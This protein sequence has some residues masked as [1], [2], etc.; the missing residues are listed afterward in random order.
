MPGMEFLIKLSWKPREDKDQPDTNV[1]RMPVV[2]HTRVI[3][4]TTKTTCHFEAGDFLV[5]DSKKSHTLMPVIE[6]LGHNI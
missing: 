6:S 2:H 5:V 4:Q 3:T 1:H